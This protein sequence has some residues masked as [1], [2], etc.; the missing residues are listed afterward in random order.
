[1]YI[2]NKV[3]DIS[4]ASIDDVCKSIEADMLY[5]EYIK[6]SYI[7]PE[8]MSVREITSCSNAKEYVTFVSTV[9]AIV[10]SKSAGFALIMYRVDMSPIE[11]EYELF[12]VQ[13]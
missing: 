1:M 8:E 5:G 11:N 2:D 9:K 12:G 10:P 4:L 3:G 6:W 13:K 7:D